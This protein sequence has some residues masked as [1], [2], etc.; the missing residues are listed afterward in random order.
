MARKVEVDFKLLMVGLAFLI[1]ATVGSAFAAVLMFRSGNELK[2][3]SPLADAA[4]KREIGP[5]YEA[6]EFI[7]NLASTGVHNRFIK[8][9]IT[10]EAKDKR[11]INE[12]EKR[13]P[14]I[15]DAI[16]S[17]IRARNGEQLRSE[18]GL[19][20]LRLEIMACLNKILIKG[21]VCNVYFVD[22]YIQ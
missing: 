20:L 7:L 8:T 2:S 1:V 18:A 5:T 17:L 4:S 9:E 14:Q 22:L 16:I 3:D 6:G 15:R 19:E 12:L 13:Q 11:T 10:L 21:E